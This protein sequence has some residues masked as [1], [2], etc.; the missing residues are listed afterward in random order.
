M[1]VQT[2][3]KILINI[4]IFLDLI[5]LISMSVQYVFISTL[6]W[7]KMS[8]N[9]RVVELASSEVFETCFRHN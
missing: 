4:L 7:A 5:K 1:T 9:D 8:F 6:N 2:V 3:Q